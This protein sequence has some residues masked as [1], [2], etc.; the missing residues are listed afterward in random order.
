MPEGSDTVRLPLEPLRQRVADA[1]GRSASFVDLTD[2]ELAGNAL[3]VTYST[4]EEDVPFVEVV[5][6]GPRGETDATPVRLD[7]PSGL[8]VYGELLRVEYA[9]RDAETDEILVSVSQRTGDD[10]RTLLG[11]GRMWSVETDHG[12]ETIE[13]TCY[14]ETPSAEVEDEDDAP[15]RDDK[16]SIDAGRGDE[17]QP[18]EPADQEGDGGGGFLSGLD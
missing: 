4:P 6:K 12:S 16:D 13:I 8:K 17:Q 11:C 2:V 5:V 14:A 18:A 7:T 9:G 3:E 15:E 1:T 10:W